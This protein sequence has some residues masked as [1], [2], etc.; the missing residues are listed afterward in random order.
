MSEIMVGMPFLLV[1]SCCNVV[2]ISMSSFIGPS[3]VS[4]FPA[5][6]LSGLPISYLCSGQ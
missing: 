6:P 1:S 2:P 4:P 3:A 5:L